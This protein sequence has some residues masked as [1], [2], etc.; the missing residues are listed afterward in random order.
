VFCGHSVPTKHLQPHDS[1]MIF[2]VSTSSDIHAHT[3][4]REVLN[5][6]YREGCY[7]LA[8]DEMYNS[9]AMSTTLL[10]GLCSTTIRIESKL[11]LNEA[12]V[13]WLRRPRS[14]QN[15][16]EGRHSQASTDL[17]NN[18]CRAALSGSLASCFQGA[19]VSSPE[20]TARA[21]DK[22]F[23]LKTAASCG[24]RI[25]DTM[26]TQSKAE[27]VSFFDR[28]NGKVVV[29]SIAGVD[30]VFLQTKELQNPTE[31]PEEAFAACPAF[32]QE[33]IPGNHHVRLNLFGP[34]A[35]AAIIDSPDLDWRANLNV[36]INAWNVPSDLRHSARRVLDC[37]GLEMGIIDLKITPSGEIVW[38]EVN[39]QGQFLFLDPLTSLNIGHNFAKWLIE[40]AAT[41]RYVL[42]ES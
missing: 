34:H 17:I 1:I 22:I 4:R 25:P 3:I 31:I 7:L 2:I 38:F 28:C 15:I 32:Y 5:L 37:L 24:F 9:T 42:G 20:A 16:E 35:L 14:A 41:H 21:S 40:I 11:S 12:R 6:G 26:I 29:K 23:Q 10:D 19:W 30:S 36:P 13:I 18:E 8:S 39:P 33:L 27:V